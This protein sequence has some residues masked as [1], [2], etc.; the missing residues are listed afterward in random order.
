MAT[1]FLDYLVT[2][3]GARALTALLPALTAVP[4]LGQRLEPLRHP[5]QGGGGN[6]RHHRELYLQ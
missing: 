3:F 4:L 2:Y 1:F 6:H 5:R